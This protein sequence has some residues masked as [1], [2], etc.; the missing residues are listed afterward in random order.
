MRT[1]IHYPP[2]YLRKAVQNWRRAS[3]VDVSD[4][5]AVLT[6]PS[7]QQGHYTTLSLWNR[8]GHQWGALTCQDHFKK[9]LPESFR[10]LPNFP[11]TFRE[12]KKTI[13]VSKSSSLQ[14]LSHDKVQFYLHALFLSK[15][16]K[17]SGIITTC[18]EHNVSQPWI[19]II[20]LPDHSKNIRFGLDCVQIW[21]IWTW[22]WWRSGS[23]WKLAP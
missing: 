21:K 1:N 6:K 23:N 9:D 3:T 13:W 10:K 4:D 12:P 5:P 16:T 22:P 14:A 15:S 2:S 20:G 18:Q 11:E 7:H 8:T 19:T 17:L